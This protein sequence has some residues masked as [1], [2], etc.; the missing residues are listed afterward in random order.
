MVFRILTLFLAFFLSFSVLNQSLAQSIENS[1]DVPIGMDI[2]RMTTDYGFSEFFMEEFFNRS[3]FFIGHNFSDRLEGLF[4]N[5]G[6]V[7]NIGTNT[8][9]FHGIRGHIAIL[10]KISVWLWKWD[11]TLHEV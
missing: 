2:P 3:S 5:D 4:Y 10:R 1:D 7:K 6:S 8:A 9:S 11:T